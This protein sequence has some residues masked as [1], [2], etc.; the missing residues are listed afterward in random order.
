MTEEISYKL[1][2]VA[3]D[4]PHCSIVP[5]NAGFYRAEKSNLLEGWPHETVWGPAMFFLIE[6]PVQGPVLFDT[7]YSTRFYEAAAHFPYS[8]MKALI[9]VR[10][11]EDENAPVQL[12][13][14]GIDPDD[15]T[16]VLSHLHID[17]TGGLYGFPHSQVYMSRRE[18]D[19][20]R[21]S[22]VAL[23]RHAY[24]K[25][26]FDSVG[27]D[28]AHLLDFDDAPAY[29]PFEH[30]RDLFGDGTMI[31][32]PLFGHTAGQIGMLV[33]CSAKERWLLV[34]DAV[35]VRKN[36]ELMRPVSRVTNILQYDAKAMLANYPLLAGLAKAN[37]ELHIAP[38]H[39]LSLYEELF[40]KQC[41]SQ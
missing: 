1:P 33:S 11:T 17:H 20:T 29:G 5:L 27:S 13:R 8:V 25:S 39:D 26:L 16:I 22:G 40:G 37:P 2:P 9:P 38:A 30:A 6:H 23:L 36:Y 10:V 15:V 24:L 12:A 3:E 14:R 7:G 19:A 4:A 18:W 21:G 28:R 32:F 34:A 31:A 41:P 35:Y